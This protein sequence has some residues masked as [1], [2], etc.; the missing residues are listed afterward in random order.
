MTMNTNLTICQNCGKLVH[1]APA[2][3]ERCGHAL[4]KYV[5]QFP[6]VVTIPQKHQ[7]FEWDTKID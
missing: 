4:S 5:S 7:S 3:C 2:I 6:K 1:L